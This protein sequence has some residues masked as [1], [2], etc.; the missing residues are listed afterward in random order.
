MSE[1]PT[2][3]IPTK[4]VYNIG[5]WPEDVST[6]DPLQVDRLQPL[7]AGAGAGD[8]DRVSRFSNDASVTDF[9]VDLKST[10]DLRPPASAASFT[11]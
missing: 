8:G 10:S 4:N 5:H 9:D 3:G 7:T 11:F 1:F 6:V 2:V